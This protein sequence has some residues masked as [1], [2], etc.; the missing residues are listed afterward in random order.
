MDISPQTE[1]FI[2]GKE[3]KTQKYF[4]R[5]IIITVEKRE[6]KN[7]LFLRKL[8]SFF[9]SCSYVTYTFG[10]KKRSTQNE[11]FLVDVIKIT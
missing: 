6:V 9:L 7:F 5:V 1:I 2:Y 8:Y 4:Q 3:P 11:C 10:H